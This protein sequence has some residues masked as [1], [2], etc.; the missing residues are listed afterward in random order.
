MHIPIYSR[1]RLVTDQYKDEGVTK[2]DIGSV[3]EIYNETNYEVEFYGEDGAD[4]AQIVVKEDEIEIVEV[5]N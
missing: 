1:V 2:G 4:Y 5:F 3:I